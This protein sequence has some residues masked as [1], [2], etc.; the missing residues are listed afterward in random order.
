MDQ[1]GRAGGRGLGRADGRQGPP[2]AAPC[3][4]GTSTAR[5]GAFAP[6]PRARCL[7]R[8]VE[9]VKP[10]KPRST[11]NPS[12]TPDQSRLPLQVIITT[13]VAG[14]MPGLD[15]SFVN[16]NRQA[17]PEGWWLGAVGGFA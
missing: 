16:A 8:S 13:K 2:E 6:R 11:Q 9:L 12:P 17:G 5:G 14:V 1:G 3:P 7:P 10:L 15:R 4:S